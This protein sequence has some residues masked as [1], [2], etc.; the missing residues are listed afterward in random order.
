MSEMTKTVQVP[1]DTIA[2]LRELLREAE[3]VLADTGAAGGEKIEALRERLRGALAEGRNAVDRLREL[4]RREAGE[5]DA[6]V[7]SHPY[8][9]VGIAIGLG[10]LLGFACSRLFR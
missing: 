8:E 1:E 3:S 2:E 4:A 6:Q 5:I 9:S 10:A 7:R